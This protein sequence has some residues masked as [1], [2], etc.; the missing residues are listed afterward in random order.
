VVTSGTFSPTFEKALGMAYVPARLDAP[1]TDLAI[2]VRGRALAA[3]VVPTPFY[4]RAK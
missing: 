3:A 1:G 2:E 4:R